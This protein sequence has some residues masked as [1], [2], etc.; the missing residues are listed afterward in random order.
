MTKYFTDLHIH[1]G[2]AKGLPVKITASNKM[3]V[4]N[5]LDYSYNVKGLDIVGIVDCASPPV[6]S[7]LEKLIS[8]G[9]LWELDDGGLLYRNGMLLILGC[10]VEI[11]V[12]AGRSHFLAYFPDL[13][14][15][16]NFS[17]WASKNLSNVQ[18]SSQCLKSDLE[19]FVKI[20]QSLD[21]IFMP[22]HAFTPFKSLLGSS[23]N[24][25]NELNTSNSDL[26]NIN[27]TAVELGLSA[28]KYLADQIPSLKGIKYITNSDAHSLNKIAREYN[29]IRLEELS[30][31]SLIKQL[32]GSSNNIENFGLH[33]QLGKYYRSFCLECETNNGF[34]VPPVTK[35]QFCSSSRIVT[36]VLD[37][38]AQ[39]SGRKDMDSNKHPHK[40]QGNYT[41]Q[42]PLEDVPGIGNKT[43]KKLI[44]QLGPEIKI[45]HDSTESELGQVV[46]A[47]IIK[48]IF[49]IR[50][51]NISLTPGGGGHYGRVKA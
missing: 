3:T 13:T 29:L 40:K 41:Y 33:P 12:G 7:E 38:I 22:A 46:S 32:S 9:E 2:Q 21:G 8:K 6:I 20:V 19:S 23:I 4:Y 35:C 49:Q 27:I 50:N 34:E 26:A 16:K 43:Y 45:I 1:V 25:L 28:D 31:K 18:L 36:G 48:K 51:G 10:E 39:L 5:I 44:R 30:F 15:L 37:R 24:N 11:P 14:A 42:V 47:R 17:N